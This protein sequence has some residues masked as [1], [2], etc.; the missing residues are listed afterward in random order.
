M[1]IRIN[2][3]MNHNL[4]D[5]KVNSRSSFAAFI[6]LLREDFLQNPN[7]WENDTLG[8]FLEAMS[9]YAKDIQGYYNNF[10]L[11]I[12]AD[13]AQWQVFA[14]ILRGAKVYE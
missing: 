14:D 4:S 2:Y 7:E 12:N 13:E 9:A 10:N 6:E 11:N 3:F 1:T 5:Y 8:N